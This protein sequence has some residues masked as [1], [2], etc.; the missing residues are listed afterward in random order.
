M[1]TGAAR[2]LLWLV[3]QRQGAGCRH[4]GGFTSGAVGGPTKLQ[5]HSVVLLHRL[6]TPVLLAMRVAD[7]KDPS[8]QRAGFDQRVCATPVRAGVQVQ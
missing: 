3:G 2:P 8:A 5:V 7:A 6:N 4:L 1:T